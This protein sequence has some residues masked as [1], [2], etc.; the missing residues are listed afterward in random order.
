MNILGHVLKKLKNAAEFHHFIN[1]RVITLET[2]IA[3]K[4][5]HF[6]VKQFN[7][8]QKLVLFKNVTEL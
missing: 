1:V 4:K 8:I 3:F 6:N 7:V 5:Y 2:Q